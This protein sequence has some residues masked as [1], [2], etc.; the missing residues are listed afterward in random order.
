MPN[1]FKH[2]L[3]TIEK[4]FISSIISGSITGERYRKNGNVLYIILY[5]LII[6]PPNNLF[7]K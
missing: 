7:E 6:S 1:F 4:K 5:P 3:L 2:I